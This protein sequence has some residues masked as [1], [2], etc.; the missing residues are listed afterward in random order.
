MYRPDAKNCAKNNEHVNWRTCCQIYHASFWMHKLTADNRVRSMLNLI[1]GMLSLSTNQLDYTLF[2]SMCTVTSMIIVNFMFPA[3]VMRSLEYMCY[4][5]VICGISSPQTIRRLDIDG[6]SIWS[7]GL[8]YW[9]YRALMRR[10]SMQSGTQRR[11]S[12]M[13]WIY[14][15]CQIAG[16]KGCSKQSQFQCVDLVR[17]PPLTHHPSTLLLKLRLLHIRC[18]AT[19]P[20]VTKAS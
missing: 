9:Y 17:T 1:Y 19:S 7:I 4:W 12:N 6:P 15:G 3:L 14:H 20:Q 8:L 10:L 2:Y 16:I 5:R 18:A 11:R 13:G